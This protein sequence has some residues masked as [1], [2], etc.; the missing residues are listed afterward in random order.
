VQRIGDRAQYHRD[1]HRTER[2]DDGGADVPQQQEQ[3]A[4]REGDQDPPDERAIVDRPVAA[5]HRNLPPRPPHGPP[6]QRGAAP[7]VPEARREPS[8]A[9]VVGSRGSKGGTVMRLRLRKIRT[10]R[11]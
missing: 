8:R 4:D 9:G 6:R 3:A 10:I 5:I 11:R 7:A 2:E 1:D